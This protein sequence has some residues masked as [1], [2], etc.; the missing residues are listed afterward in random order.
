MARN[1]FFYDNIAN[2]VYV[3]YMFFT[4]IS[5]LINASSLQV[6]DNGIISIGSRYNA[7]T[8]LSLPRSGSS[9]R[10]IAP[11]WADVDTRGTGNIYYRQTTDPSLLAR[12]TSEIRAAFPNSQSVT[13]RNLLVATWDGVGYY[14]RRSDKVLNN[15][16]VHIIRSITYYCTLYNVVYVL[17]YSVCPCMCG[18]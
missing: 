6:N 7:R 16:V 2:T 14:S 17:S 10:I 11:Y 15:I 8:P 18:Q 4:V 12:A 13:I 1:F 3:C 9:L 5:V